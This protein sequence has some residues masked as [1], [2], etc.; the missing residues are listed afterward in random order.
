MELHFTKTNGPADEAIDRLI[1]LVGDIYHPQIVREMILAALKAG[2]EGDERV[3]LKIGDI[4][5]LISRSKSRFDTILLDIDN[6]PREMT[7][8]GNRRLYGR[9]GILAC[10]RALRSQG[11]LALWSA[12]PNKKF[13]HLLMGCR[14]HV[15]RFRVPAYKGSKSPSRFVWV[16]SEDKDLLPPGGGSPLLPPKSGVKKDRRR[17]RRRFR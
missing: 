10:R 13:E 16:A 8:S 1:E 17:P 5:E 4:V 14:F 11:R 6:G 15:R 7:D 9:K 2:Q 3:D 12:E